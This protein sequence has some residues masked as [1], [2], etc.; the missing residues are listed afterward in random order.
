[1]HRNFSEKS[2]HIITMMIHDAADAG[3]TLEV[4]VETAVQEKLDVI[5]VTGHNEITNVAR[6]LA[7]G[8]MSSLLVIPGVEPSTP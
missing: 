6:V 4:I 7:A 8:A 5:A 1:M 3:M 2:L